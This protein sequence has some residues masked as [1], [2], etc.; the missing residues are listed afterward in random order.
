MPDAIINPPIATNNLGGRRLNAGLDCIIETPVIIIRYP[1]HI[2]ARTISV[3]EEMGHLKFRPRP[4]SSLRIERMF[5]NFTGPSAP[6]VTNV[7]PQIG[8]KARAVTVVLLASHL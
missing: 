3:S 6:P 5:H 2:I 8:A 7:E 1:T 4:S